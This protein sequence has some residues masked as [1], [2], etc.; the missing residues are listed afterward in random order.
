MTPH[1]NLLLKEK[2]QISTLLK[3]ARSVQIFNFENTGNCK[4]RFTRL[5]AFQSI[6]APLGEG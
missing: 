4:I 3:F 6:P 2:G 1:P 5:A